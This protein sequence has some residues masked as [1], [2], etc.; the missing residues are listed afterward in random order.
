[1]VKVCGGVDGV[2][3]LSK[4]VGMVIGGDGRVSNISIFTRGAPTVHPW[5]MMQPS[6]GLRIRSH[7]KMNMVETDRKR[8]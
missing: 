1:M 2:G 4:E 8:R 5:K 7:E 3:V 6:G